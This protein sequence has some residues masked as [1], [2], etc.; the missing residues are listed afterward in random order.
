MKNWD[1]RSQPG[2]KLLRCA[3]VRVNNDAGARALCALD[4]LSPYSD[5]CTTF[6]IG[7]RSLLNSSTSARPE[8]E[9][10]TDYSEAPAAA[11][12]DAS[13]ATN[14]VVPRAQTSAAPSRDLVAELVARVRSTR[15]RAPSGPAADIGYVLSA[16][17]SMFPSMN[18]FQCDELLQTFLARPKQTLVKTARATIFHSERDRQLAC[19][20]LQEL[21][22]V[23]D[24]LFDGTTWERSII[25]YDSTQAGVSVAQFLAELRLARP[26]EHMPG[27]AER[28]ASVLLQYREVCDVFADCQFVSTRDVAAFFKGEY[29]SGSVQTTLEAA[30]PECWKALCKR[31]GYPA[32]PFR[33]YDGTFCT[34]HV[35]ERSLFTAQGRAASTPAD[36]LTNYA[37]LLA[38]FN[39]QGKMKMFGLEKRGWYGEKWAQMAKASMQFRL[40]FFSKQSKPRFPTTAEFIKSTW[41][42]D[43]WR[44]DTTLLPRTH[45]VHARG[46]KRKTQ[47]HLS[48]CNISDA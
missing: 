15:A 10:K 5:S 22:V 4:H 25:Q 48:D 13:S 14:T 47:S 9:R 26:E 3:V 17:P 21:M 2:Y 46:V 37:M 27:T 1:A 6:K 31:M 35:V 28:A 11:S 23:L 18:R 12:R 38:F 36:S 34:D 33:E 41:C 43:E 44:P 8:Q 19:P 7:P 32:K 29:R 30:G 45:A 16:A 20:Q 24:D 42:R 40:D 39:Q